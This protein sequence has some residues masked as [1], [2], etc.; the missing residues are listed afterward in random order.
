MTVRKMLGDISLSLY[1]QTFLIYLPLLGFLHRANEMINM[2]VTFDSHMK[3]CI[4][5]AILHASI[6]VLW[7]L[8]GKASRKC[9][10][11]CSICQIWFAFASLLEIFDFEPIFDHFDAHALWHLSTVPLGFF[12][13]NFWRADFENQMKSD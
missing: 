4:F 11:Y 9:K 6:W 7:I 13:Y 8:F 3:L 10:Y 5:I 12:W 1:A 2:R